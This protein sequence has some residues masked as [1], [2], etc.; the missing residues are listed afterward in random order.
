[1]LILV[2]LATAGPLV[3][4]SE[5]ARLVAEGARVLDTRGAFAYMTEGHIPGAPRVNW[6]DA[7]TGGL[8]SGKLAD[9]ARVAQ[10]YA[11]NGV[12]ASRPV[13]VV[14]AW[15]QGW[16]EEGRVWWDLS[17][18]GH[19]Q[20]HVLRGGMQKWTGARELMP[21]TAPLGQFDPEPSA[22]MRATSDNLYDTGGILLDVREPEEF[23]GARK[24]GEARGGHIPGALNRPW[25]TFLGVAIVRGPQTPIAPDPETPITIYCTGG[26]R[27][28]MV[29]LML[30]DE[31]YTAVRNYDGSFWEW[32][33][34]GK[35]VSTK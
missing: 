20:V 15:E 24:Y 3:S 35:D 8:F 16:G 17:Y 19:D 23:A 18:L 31:G 13:L 2:A 1:M 27:S 26:V 29:A 11:E 25:K 10:F 32:A 34:S 6:K 9:P 5:A 22:G 33:A 21:A 30:A 14:G 12:D 7:T 4:P 28:A